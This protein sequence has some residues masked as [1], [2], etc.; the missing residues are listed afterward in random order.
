MCFVNKKIAMW[1]FFYYWLHKKEK[2]D[3]KKI[4]IF[5]HL[6]AKIHII[7]INTPSRHI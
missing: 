7:Q 3:L 1:N 6:L 5:Y 4:K 2:S